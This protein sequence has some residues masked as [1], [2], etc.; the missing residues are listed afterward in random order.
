MTANTAPDDHEQRLGSA[1]VV[2]VLLAGPLQSVTFE[3]TPSSTIELAVL[4]A[5]AAVGTLLTYQAFRGYRRNDDRSMAL[6]GIG[7]FLLTV[8]HAGLKLL[9]EFVGPLVAAGDPAVGLGVAA[10]SQL[11]DIL[12]L[13][14]ILYAIRQ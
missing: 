2:P 3:Q 8:A 4:V 1:G 14:V 7:L 13:A 10:T 12:G 6:F 11:V 9:L 5:L